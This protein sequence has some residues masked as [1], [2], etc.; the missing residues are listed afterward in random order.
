MNWNKLKWKKYALQ[1]IRNNPRTTT[2]YGEIIIQNNF[3]KLLLKTG[4]C[5]E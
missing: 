5:L 1:F 3:E 4:D 2:L